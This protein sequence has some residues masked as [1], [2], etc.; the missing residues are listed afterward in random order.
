MQLLR[1][2]W[3]WHVSHD[4][5]LLLLLWGRPSPPMIYLAST[6]N[7]P[8]RPTAH[9]LSG[10][11]ILMPP[12]ITCYTCEGSSWVQEITRLGPGDLLC[13]STRPSCEV[14]CFLRFLFFFFFLTESNFDTNRLHPE[15]PLLVCNEKKSFILIFF[16]WGHHMHISP[17]LQ[18]NTSV[19]QAC[20]ISTLAPLEL[21]SSRASTCCF[22]VLRTFSNMLF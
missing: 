9:V 17:S 19:T 2:P 12:Q 10:E 8:L 21:I 5:L 20:H 11:L 4:R 14:P 3:R 22:P 18:R 16:P 7:L 15:N 13:V 6:D 1:Q